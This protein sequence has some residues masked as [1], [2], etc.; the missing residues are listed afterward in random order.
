[1]LQYLHAIQSHR[2]AFSE[3]RNSL[4]NAIKT[5]R[6]SNGVCEDRSFVTSFMVSENVKKMNTLIWQDGMCNAWFR[7]LG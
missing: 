5:L 3:E 4:E 2:Y 6:E 7:E 1:M